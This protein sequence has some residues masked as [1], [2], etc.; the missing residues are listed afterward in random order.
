[1]NNYNFKEWTTRFDMRKH[2]VLPTGRI[3]AL[4]VALT[5]NI[6]CFPERH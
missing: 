2:R 4:R 1:M 5:V 6:D 3:C